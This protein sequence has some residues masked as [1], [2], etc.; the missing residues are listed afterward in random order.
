MKKKL[1]ELIEDMGG[2]SE[3]AGA[4]VS[5]ISLIVLI[6]MLAVIGG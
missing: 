5:W 6:I 2:K 4:L 1:N 3:V